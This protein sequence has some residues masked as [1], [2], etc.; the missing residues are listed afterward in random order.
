MIYSGMATIPDEPTIPKP[1]AW[2]HGE[3]R[4]PPFAREARIE[5][6]V[7]LR[8]LQNGEFVTMPRSKPLPTI[9]PRC[10]ELR[11]RDKNHNWRIVYRIDADAIIIASVFAK[12]SPAV[13]KVEFE[14]AKR[15]LRLYDQAIAN[16]EK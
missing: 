15:R 1:L 4:T 12:N 6:G 2:L 13:Q 14:N 16:E 5:A 7:L 9:G 10:H 11:I 8:M 3:I